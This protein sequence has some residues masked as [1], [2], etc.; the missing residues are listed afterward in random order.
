MRICAE[1]CVSHSPHV[2]A[3]HHYLAAQALL[4]LDNRGF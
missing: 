3:F 4:D 1:G 2:L